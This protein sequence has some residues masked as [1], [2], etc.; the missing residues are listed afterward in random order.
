MQ[1]LAKTL[2][3]LLVCAACVCAQAGQERLVST[4]Q[5]YRAAVKK[6]Q[7]GDTVVL[8]NGV[9]EDFEMVFVGEG[10]A[11]QPIQLRAEQPGKVVLSGQ[12]NLR[13]AG[14][15]LH[16]SG[17]VFSNGHSPSGQ[18][19][20]FRRN[21]EHLANHSRV[22]DVV[23][24]HYSNPDRFDSDYWVAMYGRNN[25][26]DHNHLVGKTNA[27][28]TMAVRLDSAASRDN[29][30]RID[31][32][33][34]GPRPVF[35]SNGG[36]TLRIG[37]SAYSMF[38]SN[39]AV[40]HNY[41]DRCSG[42][43]EIISSK[44]GGNLF[45]GNLFYASQGTLTLRHGD[46]N[47][48]IDNVFFGNGEPHTGGIRVINRNQEVRNNYMEGLRGTGFASALTV[49]NGV[50]NS[51]IN[52]YVQVSGALIAHNTVVN[53]RRVELGAGNDEERSAAPID[54]R[55]S[56]NLLHGNDEQALLAVLTDIS[57][58]EFAANVLSGAAPEPP[59][60]GVKTHKLGLKRASN[61]LLYPQN[62]DIT[63]GVSLSLKPLRR[64][65]TGV[66]WYP[67][68]SAHTAYGSGR[69]IE[70][71]PGDDTLSRAFA[72]AAD[73]DT[74]QLSS[75][76]YQVSKI[77]PLAH[78][79]SIVGP[80]LSAH[81]GGQ[82]SNDDDANAAIIRYGRNAL[83]ELHT[84]ARLQLAD[85]TISGSDSPDA[86]GNVVIRS[87]A[88]PAAADLAIDLRR[89]RCVDMDVNHSF[90][91]IALSKSSH[92]TSIDIV[93]S[94]FE[95]I[96]GGVLMADREADDYGRYNVERVRIVRSAFRDIGG[97]VAAIYRGGTDES[98]FGPHFTLE[99]SLLDDVGK[100]KRNRAQAS[101]LLHGVQ[102]AQVSGNRF[103]E[104]AP[105]V[106]RHTV[107]VPQTRIS[108]NQ[109]LDTDMPTLAELNWPGEMRVTLED[110]RSEQP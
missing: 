9:W 48:V 25:R 24:D 64:E 27:G 98:T 13:L 77:L 4:Q 26:F 56:G 30:H 71:E 103:I 21:K 75:G 53:S 76:V 84:G 65:Q 67:K 106:V 7:P 10:T 109:F 45:R 36:E 61:G 73:G 12:S 95:Q 39:T 105:L 81:V 58:I 89:V 47:R 72:K 86:V 1:G 88:A 33:Y 29:Q 82:Q 90:S 20:G 15:Y 52:R 43:V 97:P 3:L 80:R 5:D 99:A 46:G 66:D 94:K 55:F 92:A 78:T 35:G 107:G 17:L 108:D 8:A 32:N 62:A 19:I 6:L 70:V 85:L 110:N 93:D 60:A 54:T 51:P 96:S 41:F 37:T 34:F 100:N 87:A 79:V 49:M 40:E 38:D 23:I 63:A 2:I 104:S 42:E 57:G 18:V 74:L 14:S 44:A 16:V 50:P 91:V 28:V 83:F 31:H 22:S 69:Q 59:I 68:P 102:H 11:E 101:V